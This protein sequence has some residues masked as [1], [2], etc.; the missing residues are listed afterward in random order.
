[1]AG[2][3]ARQGAAVPPEEPRLKIPLDQAQKVLNERISAG[4]QLFAGGRSFSS[5]DDLDALKAQ[6]YTW[7]E[8][9][10]TWLERYVG[11]SVADEYRSVGPMIGGMPLSE[12][13]RWYDNDVQSSVRRLGSILDRLSLWADSPAPAA[14]EGQPSADAPI[15]VVHG[16]DHGLA[17][18]VARVLERATGREAI[19]LHEQ[20]NQGRTILEKFEAHAEG[21]AFAVVLLT[22]DDEGR[23]IGAPDLRPRGRQNV[24]FELGFFFGMLGRSRV[25]VLV[26]EGVEHPSDVAGLVYEVVDPA[27]SWKQALARE[28]EAAGIGVNHSRIP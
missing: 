23:K 10:Y 2:R 12:K 6:Y 4:R 17:Y 25:M 19:I 28:L 7:E 8:Y 16:H 24:I 22:G 27:G 21:V 26:S 20:A 1:M 5:E 14:A 3:N 13:V 11:K 15:F 18:Q 9:N